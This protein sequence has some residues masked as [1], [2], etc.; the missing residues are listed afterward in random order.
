MGYETTIKTGCGCRACMEYGVDPFQSDEEIAHV[1]KLLGCP[2]K[3]A[4]NE[5]E[6]SAK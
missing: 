4:A 5:K 1:K 3:K 6:R 2:P